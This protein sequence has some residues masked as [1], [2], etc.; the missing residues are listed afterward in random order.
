MATPHTTVR[1]TPEDRRKIA[2]L[3]HLNG[4]LTDVQTIRKALEDH[5]ERSQQKKQ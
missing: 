5:L 4:Y 1:L 2:L 3:K